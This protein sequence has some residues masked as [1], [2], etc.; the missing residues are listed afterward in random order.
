MTPEKATT[1]S[2]TTSVVPWSLFHE[3]CSAATFQI[4]VPTSTPNAGHATTLNRRARAR[5]ASGDSLPRPG[6][7]PASVIWPPT[8]TEAAN[9]CRN[10]RM[11]SHVTGSTAARPYPAVR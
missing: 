4:P 7:K 3:T 5:G 10:S 11:V 1:A 9:T 6:T 8:Q 2:F